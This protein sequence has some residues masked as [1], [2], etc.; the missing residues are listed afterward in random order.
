MALSAAYAIPAAPS[1]LCLHCGPPL[2]TQW[3]L[4]GCHGFPPVLELNPAALSAMFPVSTPPPPHPH[5]YET[6]FFCLPLIM[7]GLRSGWPETRLPLPPL[8]IQGG[9]AMPHHA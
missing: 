5:L 3:S 7:L 6:G 8:P 4:G 1:R 2:G 9:K